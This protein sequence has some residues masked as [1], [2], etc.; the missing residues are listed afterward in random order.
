MM[1]V[2]DLQGRRIL[3]TG[4]SSGIG[5]AVARVL[6]GC[7]A[8]LALCN[9]SGAEAAEFM[10]AELGSDM[11]LIRGDVTTAEGTKGIAADGVTALGLDGFVHGAG[12]ITRTK[13]TDG[14]DESVYDRI[15]DLN[16]R[17]IPRPWRSI[18]RCGKGAIE[19]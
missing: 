2:E 12:A 11:T 16:I 18:R 13:L 7:G 19:S 15:F 6:A 4:A 14:Y 10:R 17:S 1:G 8:R 5:A 9:N 3:I